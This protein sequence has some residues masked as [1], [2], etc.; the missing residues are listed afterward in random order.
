MYRVLRDL[1]T[2]A[3]V[4]DIITGNGINV[5]VLLKVR[6]ISLVQAPPLEILPEVSEKAGKLKEYGIEDIADF[7]EADNDILEAA[8][9]DTDEMRLEELKEEIMD[10]IL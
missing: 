7:V 10:Y 5:E 6:A 9:E 3:K 2:G 4:G 1:D 8:F